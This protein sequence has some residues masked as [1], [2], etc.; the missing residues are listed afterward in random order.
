MVT[1]RPI[2]AAV[3]S[4]IGFAEKRVYGSSAFYYQHG[5]LPLTEAAVEA[6]RRGL[7]GRLMEACLRGPADEY[8]VHL[9]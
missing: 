5:V 4:V 2:V 1:A 9:P 6:E 3:A 8:V 7:K